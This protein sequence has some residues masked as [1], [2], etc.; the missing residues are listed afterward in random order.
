MQ[1]TQPSTV[2]MPNDYKTYPAITGTQNIL[3]SLV[4]SLSNDKSF[5]E[6]IN[7]MHTSTDSGDQKKAS[8]IKY[9]MN[10]IKMFNTADKPL[11]LAKDIGILLGTTRH[12][13]Q[14]VR[15]YDSEEKVIGYI[16]ESNGKTKK[17][18]FL[19]KYGI[20]KCIHTS[21]SPLSTLLS[22]FITDLI[23][24]TLTQDFKKVKQF[25]TRF[26]QQNPQL[27][28]DG[29]DDL[30]IKL[31]EYKQKYIAEQNRAK[32]LE[33]QVANEQKKCSELEEHTTEMEI[34]KSYN[35]MYI[36]QLKKDKANQTNRLKNMSD[37][38]LDV[39]ESSTTQLEMKLLKEKFMKTVYIYIL[40]PNY[41]KKLAKK[42]LSPDSIGAAELDDS[43][44]EDAEPED[45]SNTV[46]KPI[47]NK[48]KDS[49]VGVLV[50]TYDT[51]FTRVYNTDTN[52]VTIDNDELLY[53]CT[54]MSRNIAKKDKYIHV[55]TEWV[56]DKSHYTRVLESLKN[57][58]TYISSKK[59][60]N[61]ATHPIIFE[62]SISEV[63][64]IIKEEFINQ[65]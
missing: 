59:I 65:N 20:H 18:M 34:Q 31:E 25:A 37:E 45:D 49:V 27:V 24:E 8:V 10:N 21:H 58:C 1:T 52:T 54:S 17:V 35:N 47:V 38:F 7:Q 23:E 60:N 22:R 42:R 56:L 12:I 62:T 36:E 48:R 19:T 9:T 13:D 2:D 4:D 64:D 26:Q 30:Q 41:M 40:H 14:I 44:E 16:N 11:F 57:N 28:M 32:L 61:K 43:D 3:S 6:H 29:M 33:E 46:K 55:D 63:K 5:Q 53:F 50:D 51:I 39:T 15:K